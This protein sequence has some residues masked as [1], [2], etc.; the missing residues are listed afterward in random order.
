[1]AGVH[2]YSDRA[3]YEDDPVWKAERAAESNWTKPRPSAI[4]ITRMETAIVWPA[5]Y[6]GHVP[7]LLRTVQAVALARTRDRD[8]AH[9]ARRLGLPGRLARRRNCEGL[10]LIAAG[11]RRDAVV[12]F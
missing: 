10:D 2:E 5:R 12:V 1:V 4:E 3:C 6:L 9:A 11:L 8:A 7:Q